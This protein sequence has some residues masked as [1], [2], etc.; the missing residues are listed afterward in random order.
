MRPVGRR[1]P[2]WYRRISVPYACYALSVLTLLNLLNYADRNV[3]VALVEPIKGEFSLSDK[4]MGLLNFA[5]MLSFSLSAYPIARLSDRGLR[6]NIVALGGILWSLA[7]FLTGSVHTFFQLFLCRAVLGVGEAAYACTLSPMLSDYFPLRLRATVISIA[8]SA[9]G[10]GTALGFL[11]GGVIYHHIGWRYAFYAFGLPGI[12]LAILAYYLK[13]P[14]RGLPERTELGLHHPR[15]DFAVPRPENLLAP[16]REILAIPTI[17][18]VCLTGILLTFSLG[19]FFFWLPSFLE[20]YHGFS[21]T[22]VATKLSMIAGCGLLGGM[23]CGGFLADALQRRG[24]VR[25][26]FG[27]L[28]CGG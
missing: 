5:F 12:V 16:A 27:P 3:F 26:T 19:G 23:V 7:T 13:E 14:V 1:K 22:D 18:W 24:G 15:E 25:T 20:R 10:L 21:T 8:A 17:R 4:G 9:L 11:V 28:S 6:K 2:I